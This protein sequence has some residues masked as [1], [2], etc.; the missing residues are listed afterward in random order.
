MNEMYIAASA[1]GVPS[2]V[3]VEAICAQY[4]PYH[5]MPKFT[6]GFR[7]YLNGTRHDADLTGVDGQA[8]DR[9]LEAGM[10]TMRQAQWIEQN[11]GAN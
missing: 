2:Y 5:T 6:E 8:Y 11:V 7:D 10:K 9:G 4:V 1:A 3:S